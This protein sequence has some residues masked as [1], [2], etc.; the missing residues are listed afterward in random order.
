[1]I[2]LASPT[3]GQGPLE[4]QVFAPADVS[5]YG[6]AIEPNEGYF[7]Q[8]DVLYWSISAPKSQV[9]GFPGMTRTVSYGPHPIDSLDSYSD[10]RVETSTL[11]TGDLKD[12][13]SI[14]N[15]FEF[16]QVE[17]RNGWTVGI[18]QVRNQ[19]DN[20][21]YP[22][23]DVVFND[24]PQGSRGTTLLEG[25]VP[26]NPAGFP[27]DGHV[28]VRKLP[29]VLYNVEMITQTKTWGVEANYL[30]RFMTGHGGGTF[31][32]FGGARYLEINDYFGIHAG[33]DPGNLVVPSFLADSSWYTSADNHVVGPQVGLRWFKKQG[34]WT[35]STE[36]RFMA[37]LNCQNVHQT[38]SLGPNL[39]P[40]GIEGNMS[41]SGNESHSGSATGSGIYK[42]VAMAPQSAAND[43]YARVFT[44]LIELRVE[45][46]YQITRSLSFHAGWT[47]FWMDNIA[48][49]NAL[50]DYSLPA[51][52]INMADNKQNLFMN[53]LT[54]GFD[55][56]R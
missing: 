37:G 17:D 5:T 31:E 35:F 19:G 42:P 11:N 34:R 56:N 40:G 36:G 15:R 14:G 18:F 54:I 22:Q 12:H 16:G 32:M 20:L 29:V 21:V 9:V 44:P 13:F 50:I 41:D 30:H 48:R 52:G 26:L 28:D 6:G 7:F 43:A 2:L 27:A 53:G 8:Y 39:T 33:D 55:I 1:M 47:G 49:A 24:P 46:R 23:A 10:E 3:F 38:V 4:S 25:S 51:M 45:G